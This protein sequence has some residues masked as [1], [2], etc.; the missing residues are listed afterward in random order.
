[1][2][3]YG[4][5]QPSIVLYG[6]VGSLMVRMVPYVLIWSCLVQF[7]PVGPVWSH[8]IPYEISD[9]YVSWHEITQDSIGKLEKNMKSVNIII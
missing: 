4:P 9:N 2:F 1:M 7:G 5:R 8:L 6:H 3:L